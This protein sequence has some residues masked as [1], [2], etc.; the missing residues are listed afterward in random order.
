MKVV[1]YGVAL[2]VQIGLF[3]FYVDRN[4]EENSCRRTSSNRDL[5]IAFFFLNNCFFFT[6]E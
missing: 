3:K 2:A 6:K 4:P 5:L 1:Y